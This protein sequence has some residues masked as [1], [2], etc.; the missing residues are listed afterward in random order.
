M[1]G[2]ECSR[3]LSSACLIKNMWLSS[4]LT[5]QYQ[6]TQ[7]QLLGG[8]YLIY[9]AILSK[10]SIFSMLSLFKPKSHFL[11]WW[12]Q[13]MHIRPK[14]LCFKVAASMHT[15]KSYLEWFFNNFL[16]QVVMHGIACP[17]CL[18]IWCSLELKLPQNQHYF[19]LIRYWS[20]ENVSIH[21]IWKSAAMLFFSF[22]N[23]VGF[24]FAEQSRKIS[25]L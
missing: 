21:L 4:S 1:V 18:Q 3:F 14:Q 5:I 6:L 10:H 7:Y 13:A 9:P 15:I 23:C 24:S 19:H 11:I 22:S 25:L 20:Q 16:F 17:A 12:M 8:E 2:K